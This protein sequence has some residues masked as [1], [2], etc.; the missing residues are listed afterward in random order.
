ML[1]L[2]EEWACFAG[3]TVV[4]TDE[5]PYNIKELEGRTVNVL[6]KDGVYR[7]A[8]FKSYGVQPLMEVEF[9][10]GRTIHA[11]PE[12]KWEVRNGSG[13]I[14]EV[15]TEEL[16]PSSHRIKRTVA[17]RPEKDAAYYEGVRHGFMFG[18]DSQHTT[19]TT[20]AMFCGD[21]DV[22]MSPYFEGQGNA[23]LERKDCKQTLRKTDLSG[24][25]KQLPARH[26][27][28]SYW[29]GFV[30]GFIAAGDTV[31]TYGCA[32]LTQTDKSVLTAI[33]EQLPRLG[34]IAGP[35]RT[36]VR[37]TEIGGRHYKDHEIH[38]M[39]LLKQFMQPEDI[40]LESHQEKFNEHYNPDSNYGQWMRIQSVKDTDRYEEVFCCE[41]METHRFVVGMGIITSN[42]YGNGFVRLAF[43]FRRTLQDTRTKYREYDL[44]MFEKHHDVKY[45]WREMMYDVPDPKTM[46]LPKS[47]QKR[48]KLKFVDRPVKDLKEIRYHKLDPRQVTLQHS[49]TSKRSQVIWR[50]EPELVRAIKDGVLH[51]VNDLPKPMLQAIANDENFLFKRDQIFHLKAPTISGI[52]NFGWGLPEVIANYR[53]IHQLQVYKKIDEAVGMDYMLPFRVFT[54]QVDGNVNDASINMLFGPWKREMNNMITN[55]RKD[56]FA[57]YAL[58]FPVNYQEI[59]ATGKELT[60][61][62]LMEFQVNDLLDS[63]GYP[64]E[65][66]RGS[67]QVQ[68]IPT[69]L[70]LFENSFHFLHRGFDRLLKWSVERVLDYMGRE[71][72]GVELQLPRMADDLEK[73]HIY[74]QLSAG[75][76]IP[77]AVAYRPMGIDDPV[78]AA[79]QR[80]QED[81]EIAKV[82]AKIEQE[83]TRE[84]E[85]GSMEGI[86]AGQQAAAQAGG[87]GVPSGGGGGNPMQLQEEAMMIAQD[88]V[89]QNDPQITKQKLVEI[90]VNPN[91]EALVRKYMKE[92]RDDAA[93]QG[94]ASAPD[95]MKNADYDSDDDDDT[96]AGMITRK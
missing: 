94:R 68:Q 89:A 35:I 5:G 4:H 70:R 65:L 62:D 79:K 48:I 22:A 87:G 73:R 27:P 83:S 63:M 44:S 11:T 25:F 2:G 15:T 52:S 55:R 38:S 46:E 20:T 66:F 21:K 1:E 58:P 51:Q 85:E 47:K 69:A 26:A 41:E 42:C 43:P 32:I 49:W 45:L 72:I 75:A 29:Y 80:A 76:E 24:K 12:H 23:V 78:E 84:M 34:M 6:S 30:C 9:C 81:A 96:A 56:P 61:K 18:A 16:C 95:M 59:G 90:A 17:P 13:E 39:T 64:A 36:Q 71:Q 28:A 67:L 53:S 74:M 14:V 31:D 7:P 10:D 91:L 57:M 37:D 60:P 93:S 40:L 82:V 33:E 19:N 8:D 3:D 77:R 50:F 92:I 86:I 88:L 54:P